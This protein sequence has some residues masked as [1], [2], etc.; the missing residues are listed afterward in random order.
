MLELTPDGFDRIRP[1][2]ADGVHGWALI[3]AVLEGNHVGRVFVDDRE[4]PSAALVALACEFTYPLGDAKNLAVQAQMKGL[5]GGELLPGDG[6]AFVFPTSQA[7]QT[8]F[9]ALLADAAELIHA[10]RDEYRFDRRQFERAYAGWRDAVP[11][12]AAIR[13]YNRALAKGQHLEAFWGGLDRFLARG[14]GVAVTRDGEAVSRCHSVMVGA[15]RA[16]IS[17]ETTEPHRRQGL[18]T[19]AACAFIERCFEAGLEPAWSN[20]DSNEASR[21]LA[22][23]LGFVHVGRSRA[24]IAKLG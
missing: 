7:W 11:M 22:Q 19:L 18:A 5:L 12:G 2:L 23:K 20:W 15:G 21:G 4:A 3:S 9:E 24:L 1:L 8:V 13:D 6:Y 16:E 17:I 10:S 14:I